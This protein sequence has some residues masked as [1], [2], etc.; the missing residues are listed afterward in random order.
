MRAVCRRFEAD[1]PERSPDGLRT[2][3]FSVERSSHTHFL[4][5][6]F[7]AM[8]DRGGAA[9]PIGKKV[10]RLSNRLFRCWYRLE[11]EAAA[12][13][14]H[15]LP[16]TALPRLAGPDSCPTRQVGGRIQTIPFNE[17]Q[18]FER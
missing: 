7:Q 2:P 1:S 10:L 17:S 16:P 6:D 12:N 13:L 15:S 8:I 5:R 9:E 14:V 3:S 18:R 4:R 11:A